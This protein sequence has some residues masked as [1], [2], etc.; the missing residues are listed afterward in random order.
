MLYKLMFLV[1]IVVMLSNCMTLGD[2]NFD[3]KLDANEKKWLAVIGVQE[4]L[5]VI[6][7]VILFSVQ[8][9]PLQERSH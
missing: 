3:N 9:K 8:L 2:A 1:L 7:S 5:I 6:G 4:I